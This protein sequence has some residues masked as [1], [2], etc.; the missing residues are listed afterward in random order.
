L[1]FAK[2]VTSIRDDYHTGARRINHAD[3]SPSAVENHFFARF[4]D[5]LGFRP[6]LDTLEM[7]GKPFAHTNGRELATYQQYYRGLPVYTRGYAVEQ[8]A[9]TSTIVSF[10]GRFATN[11]D[12]AIEPKVEENLALREALTATGATLADYVAEAQE[13]R[14]S[15]GK[16]GIAIGA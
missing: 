7:M 12:V 1:P 14:Q 6:C 10:S 8:A 4:G 2:V 16:R 11:I 13:A 5:E 9:G 15:G 3:L